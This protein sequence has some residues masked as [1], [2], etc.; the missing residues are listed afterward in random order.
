DTERQEAEAE[1]RA[2]EAELRRANEDLNLFAFAASH[3]LLGGRIWVES[4][5]NEGSAFYFTLPITK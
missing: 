5:V 1:R 3:D 4:Q 2:A